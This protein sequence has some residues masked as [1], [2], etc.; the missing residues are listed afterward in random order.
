MLPGPFQHPILNLHECDARIVFLTRNTSMCI[1]SHYITLLD[2]H[3][4]CSTSHQ[5][6]NHQPHHIKSHLITSHRA[7]HHIISH[8]ITSRA[9]V[10]SLGFSVSGLEIGV[11]G[12]FRIASHHSTFCDVLHKRFNTYHITSIASHITSLATSHH[13]T[14]APQKCSHQKYEITSAHP[15]T[16]TSNLINKNLASHISTS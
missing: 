15:I 2:V 10:A 13:V 14:A 12:G 11:E 7:A 16:S 9:M 8:Q 3:H 6:S 5:T 4:M 1:T